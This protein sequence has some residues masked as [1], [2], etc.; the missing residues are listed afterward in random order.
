MKI[1]RAIS[2][3]QSDINRAEG[4]LALAVSVIQQSLGSQE[5]QPGV[6]YGLGCPR[7]SPG[8]KGSTGKT[9]SK[10]CFLVHFKQYSRN[11]L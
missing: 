1:E 5:E 10:W 2:G 7:L 3:L 9:Y 8:P 6:K 4:Y 11:L